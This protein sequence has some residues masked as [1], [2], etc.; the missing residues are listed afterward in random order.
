MT[1]STEIQTENCLTEE[2]ISNEASSISSHTCKQFAPGRNKILN[3]VDGAYMEVRRKRWH[4]GQE[5]CQMWCKLGLKDASGT[6]LMLFDSQDSPRARYVLQVPMELQC[7]SMH[8]GEVD[9]TSTDASHLLTL[10]CCRAAGTDCDRPEKR[11]TTIRFGC[12]QCKLQWVE[13]IRSAENL[14]E[15][16]GISSESALEISPDQ[17]RQNRFTPS[18][19]PAALE[20]STGCAERAQLRPVGGV[21]ADI[22]EEIS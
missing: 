17:Q 10:S 8:V 2:K 5:W 21:D 11:N 16:L 18:S 13:A 1:A 14:F 6:R 7:Q 22:V 3:A 15:A 19:P 20:P 4:G 12:K 9:G